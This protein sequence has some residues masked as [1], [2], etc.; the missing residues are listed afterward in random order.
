MA[1][2]KWA[3]LSIA[4]I[5]S[6]NISDEQHNKNALFICLNASILSGLIH[7]MFS[8]VT[9]MPL[10]QTTMI[11]VF[12]WAWGFYQLNANNKDHIQLMRIQNKINPIKHMLFVLLL[13]YVT[14]LMVKGIFPR[15]YYLTWANSITN[16]T[17]G[18]LLAPRFW[19][20]GVLQLFPLVNYY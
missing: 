10:S 4:Q 7:S 18:G 9:T 16:F 15:V 1:L 5:K 19:G 14:L 20:Q 8:G 6:T 13:I 2:Y 11:L 3:K 12:G 17:T